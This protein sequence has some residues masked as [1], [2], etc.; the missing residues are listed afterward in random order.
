MEGA[1]YGSCQHSRCQVRDLRFRPSAVLSSEVLLTMIRSLLAVLSLCLWLAPVATA[2]PH[3]RHAIKP[4]PRVVIRGEVLAGNPG[5]FRSLGVVE[6][7]AVFLQI[8]A[9]QTLVR[10]RL[11]RTNPRYHFLLRQANDAFRAAM[12]RVAVQNGVDLVVETGGVSAVG[13]EIQD[14]TA[15]VVREVSPRRRR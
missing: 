3:A 15:G 10:E 2:T 9:Y 12:T 11:S 6:R 7:K 4:A 13:L 8:P 5:A 14:L 1:W